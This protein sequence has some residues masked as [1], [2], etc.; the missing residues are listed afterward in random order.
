MTAAVEAASEVIA[1]G[2]VVVLP[3]ESFY[4]LGVD[5][6]NGEAVDRVF[7]LKGRPT[8]LAL[9]V[10]CSDWQQV[11][12]LVSIPDA[13]RIKLSR[14][15]PAALSVIAPC[16]APLPASHTETLAVRL[17]DHE[18]LRALVYR[19]GPLTA[20]SANRHGEPPSTEV[21]AALESLLGAPDLVLD[22][23]ELAGGRVSTIVDLT[24]D[25]PRVLRFGRVA[26][27]QELDPENGRIFTIE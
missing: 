18:M 15:W 2:G 20:T 11:E 24:T 17:P 27:E 14:I 22:G 23:G 21:E 3:T 12:A 5:P 16:R 8:E 25:P 4:G 26:W 13:H 19:V 1:S 9:P 10:V 6:R 7:A